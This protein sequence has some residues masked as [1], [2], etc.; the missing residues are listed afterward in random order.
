[1]H[2]PSFLDIAR[3]MIRRHG[4]RAQAVAVQHA[5]EMRLQGDAAG[6]DRW[7][8]T[9]AA[10][11]ELR[12]TAMSRQWASRQATAARAGVPGVVAD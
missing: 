9:H 10:I 1:M 7:Q 11:C 2:K 3:M 5:A 8:R 6:L 4:L 12:R